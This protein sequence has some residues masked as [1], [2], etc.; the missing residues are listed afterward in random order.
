MGTKL[1]NINR[2]RR[3]LSWLAII[4]S[5]LSAKMVCGCKNW[6]GITCK[7]LVGG[8]QTDGRMGSLAPPLIPHPQLNMLNTGWLVSCIVEESNRPSQ[9]S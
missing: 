2:L 6:A 1:G 4:S 9:I 8:W 5:V 7:V 3:L